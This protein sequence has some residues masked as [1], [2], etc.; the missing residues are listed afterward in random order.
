MIE[1]MDDIDFNVRTLGG[2]EAKIVLS[3]ERLK[4]VEIDVGFAFDVVGDRVQAIRALQRLEKKGWLQR[5]TP[6]R[7][8]L[9]AADQGHLDVRALAPYLYATSLAP[10]GYVGWWTAAAHHG[11]TWQRPMTIFVASAKQKREADF[12]GYRIVFVKQPA[13]RQFGIEV[14]ERDTFPVSTI[15]KTVVD[16][17]NRVDLAGGASEVGIIL[18]AGVEKVGVERIVDD[19]LRMSSVSM[20]QR[21]GFLLDVVRPDLFDASQRLILKSKI[22]SSHRSVFGRKAAED[23]D[24]GYIRDW[25]LQVNLNSP[26]FRAETDRFGRKR[27]STGHFQRQPPPKTTD[28]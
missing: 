12:D 26:M 11:L 7:Y 14:D 8:L 4:K 22:G 15:S 24:F 5:I 9:L 23:G 27:A 1:T 25:G 20:L 3:A 16:C 6:G 28:S 17:V 19:A 10:A 13:E 18:G 21:L 2:L